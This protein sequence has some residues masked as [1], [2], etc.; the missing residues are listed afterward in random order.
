MG[1]ASNVVKKSTLIVWRFYPVP[2]YA[3]NAPKLK[4]TNETFDS[5]K[6]RTYKQKEVKGHWQKLS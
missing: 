5:V 2:E 3:F 4:N 6:D 1:F